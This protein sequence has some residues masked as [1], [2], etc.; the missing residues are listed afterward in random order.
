MFYNIARI[1]KNQIN[2]PWVLVSVVLFSCNIL[3][4]GMPTIILIQNKQYCLSVDYWIW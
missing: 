3:C 4:T 2:T 1:K